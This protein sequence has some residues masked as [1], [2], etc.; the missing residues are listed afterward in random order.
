MEPD[1]TLDI[2]I[3]GAGLSGINAAY[4]LQK[5]LPHRSFTI[6]ESRSRIGGTWDFWKYPGARTDSSMAVFG[7]D[8]YPWRDSDNNMAAAHAIRQYIEDAAVSEGIDKKIQFGHRVTSVSWSTEEQR[9]TVEIDASADDGTVVKKVIKAWFIIGASGYYS[10]EKPLP[11]E[12]PGIDKFGGEV[13]HP[14]FWDESINYDGKRVVVIGSGATAITLVPALAKTAGKVTMLQR[15][16]SYVFAL[17]RKVPVYFWNKFLPTSWS[18]RLN[19]WMRMLTELLFTSFV[20]AY[21]NWAKNYV[22]KEMRK[23]LPKDIDVD[24]HFNPRYNVM[25]QRLCYCPSGDFFKA[26]HKS[27]TEIVTDTIE[28]VTESGIQL[29][30][31]Q[32]IDADMIITATGLYLRLFNGIAIFV[33]GTRVDEMLGQR[34]VWNGTMLEGIPNAGLLIGYI[35]R[36]WTP[37]ADVRT[38]HLIK[39][40]KRMEK[41]G[42]TSI[43]PIPKIEERKRFPKHSAMPLTS[44]Y[45]VAARDR[46]PM[47]AFV[48]PWRSGNN[49]ASDM[50]RLMFGSITDGVKYTY[51]AKSKTV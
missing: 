29:K 28:T 31:G 34:Y 37:G 4:R 36:T 24:K 35:A 33:D 43:T 26:L 21:P 5:E 3:I 50:W 18:D 49:W 39:V 1:S 47:S 48:G 20:Q 27:N 46:V 42:A 32:T 6:L 19:W 8:W 45:A 10:Y 15:S 22:K 12:I 41:T 30:S 17:P 23:R 40:M 25:E 2:V 16:P 13:V 7:F 51:P 11:A 38:R 9:W 44:T 14:Q